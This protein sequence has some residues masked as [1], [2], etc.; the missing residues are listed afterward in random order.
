MP[1]TLSPLIGVYLRWIARI[2]VT[3]E[4]R[5]QRQ[6]KMHVGRLCGS[7]RSER[8]RYGGMNLVSV[9]PLRL[10]QGTRV[11]G[12]RVIRR[13]VQVLQLQDSSYLQYKHVVKK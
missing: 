9:A 13:W 5:T 10:D 12:E 11:C 7:E 4:A 8:R 2:A 3:G 1:N 6:S